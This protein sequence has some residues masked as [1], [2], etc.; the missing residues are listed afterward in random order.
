M[1]YDLTYNR[2]LMN[3]TNEKNRAR[4]IEIK[5]TLTVTRGEWGKG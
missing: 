3:K 4:D 1:P 2:Y 5:N